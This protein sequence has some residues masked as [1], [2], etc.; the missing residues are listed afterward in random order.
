MR[1]EAQIQIFLELARR[2]YPTKSQEAILEVEKM[3][4]EKMGGA[5]C[6]ESI[7]KMYTTPCFFH[8]L[9]NRMIRVSR[10][11]SELFCCQK[12]IHDLHKGIM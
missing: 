11:A 8:E 4:K 10:A 2:I 7:I 3:Y 9:L 1:G 12:L 6:Y 5:P